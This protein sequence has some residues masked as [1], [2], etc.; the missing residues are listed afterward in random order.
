MSAAEG[1]RRPPV[2]I[3]SEQSQIEAL[4]SPVRGLLLSTL[5]SSGPCSV[6]ELARLVGR[7]P[8]ALYYHLD[9]LVACGLVVEVGTRPTR[10]R[11]ETLY[12]AVA[13]TV[14]VDEH[15][16]ENPAWL[17]A[18]RRAIAASLRQAM[19]VHDAALTD[20][21][22]VT[23]GDCPELRMQTM[24]AQLTPEG[25]TR[26]MGK[27]EELLSMVREEREKRSGRFY[28]LTLSFAPVVDAVA[29]AGDDEDDDE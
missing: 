18:H 26:V 28:S 23:G 19:R 15:A 10:R 14:M 2:H 29:L 3:I 17:D 5:C 16:V 8:R 6:G 24:Q 13:D 12:D 4:V 7:K 1:E 27:L 9:A 22:T 11:Q 25:L 20:P 21:T